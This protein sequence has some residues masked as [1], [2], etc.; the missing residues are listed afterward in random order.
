MSS[1]FNAFLVEHGIKCQRK[2]LYTPQQN[3]VSKRKN[4]SL[5]EMERCM[6]KSLALPHSFELEVV[7]CAMQHMYLIC[8]PPN[9]CNQLLHMRLD[10]VASHLLL[11]CTF[12]GV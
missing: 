12:L 10:M 1:Q 5:M 11:I 2:L 8:I 9:H 6:V 3:R 4:K 7:M